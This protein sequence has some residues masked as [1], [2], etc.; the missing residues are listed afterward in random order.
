VNLFQAVVYGIVQGLSEFLPISS[1]GHLRIVPALFGWDDPGAAFSA[2]IQLGTMLAV[3]VYFWRELMHVSFAWLRGLVDS[4]VRPSLEYRLG[5]YLILATIP[6]GVFGFLFRNQIEVGARNLWLIASTLI[7]MALFLLLA[8]R[9]GT[10]TRAEEDLNRNDAI[11]VGTAQ[12]LAL[13]P[14]VSR[15]GSTITAG[16][17]R[18]LTRETAARFSFLLSVPAVVGS[19]LFEARKIGD[20]GGPGMGVTVVATIFSF[21]VGLAT[22]AWLLRY[23]SSHSMMIFV[24]YRIVLGVLLMSLLASGV[25]SAT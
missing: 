8:E 15:S 18:G 9:V 3:V 16:M 2:V 23:I 20:A 11:V 4:S 10:R 6:V 19:G 14:G 25:I 24:V 12:A 17:F 7:I 13:I 1:S 5:W 22:I 21:G